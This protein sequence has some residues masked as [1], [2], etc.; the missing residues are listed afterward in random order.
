MFPPLLDGT[1]FWSSYTQY[2]GIP[3]ASLE[4]SFKVNAAAMSVLLGNHAAIHDYTNG[5]PN[6]VLA[7]LRELLDAL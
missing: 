4:E 1:N 5:L 3:E 7:P 6:T 2:D